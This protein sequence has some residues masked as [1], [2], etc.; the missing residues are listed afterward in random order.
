MVKKGDKY[1]IEIGEE[2]VNDKCDFDNTLYRVKGFKSLV[3]DKYGL[4]KLEKYE[5]AE[6]LPAHGFKVG[7][8]IIDSERDLGVVIISKP[9]GIMYMDWTTCTWFVRTSDLDKITKTGIRYP[10][11]V[12]MLESLARRKKESRK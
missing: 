6:E 1:I 7:D 4:D 8:E 12:Y 2:L 5:D 11:V 3:F 9:H 10:E